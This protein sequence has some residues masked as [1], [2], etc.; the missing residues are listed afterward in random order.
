M[1][2]TPFSYYVVIGLVLIGFVVVVG[3]LYGISFIWHLGK[4]DA[5]HFYI[6][7]RKAKEHDNET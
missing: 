3:V 4:F 7:S 2:P 6:K 5:T 1:N